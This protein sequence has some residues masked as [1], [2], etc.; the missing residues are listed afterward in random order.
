MH[1]TFKSMGVEIA[2]NFILSEMS[3][4]H[5]RISNINFP[6]TK[7]FQN[8]FLIVFRKHLFYHFLH[9]IGSSRMVRI[10]NSIAFSRAILWFT[11]QQSKPFS[12]N[13]LHLPTYN[14]FVRNLLNHEI[15]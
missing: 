15:K 11:A 10:M 5:Q 3:L 6:K 1:R 2:I 12:L 4:L 9:I 7:P 14:V 8:D 13:I